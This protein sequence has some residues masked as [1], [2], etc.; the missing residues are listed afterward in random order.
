MSQDYLIHDE[1]PFT[2]TVWS[3]CGE[4]ASLNINSQVRVENS[5][6]PKGMGFLTTDSIDGKVSFKVGVK[7]QVCPE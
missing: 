6:N 2:S 7:W 5:A 4:I 1:I 3:P